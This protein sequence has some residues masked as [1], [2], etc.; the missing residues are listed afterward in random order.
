MA[1]ASLAAL[2]RLRRTRQIP[3]KR[4]PARPIT[5][6]ALG[7]IALALQPDKGDRR[8]ENRADCPIAVLRL[9]LALQVRGGRAGC[10]TGSL[11]IEA[12]DTG[13]RFVVQRAGFRSTRSP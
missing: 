2:D 1:L 3:E 11:G 4:S 6:P 8:C 10:G 9:L 12:T 5:V 13:D 7:K